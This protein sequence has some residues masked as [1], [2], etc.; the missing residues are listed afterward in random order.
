MAQV[1]PRGAA[2]V[3]AVAGV[4][5]GRFTRHPDGFGFVAP[6][7]KQGTDVFIPPDAIGSR[8]SYGPRRDPRASVIRRRQSSPVARLRGAQIRLG[9]SPVNQATASRAIRSGTSCRPRNSR[10]VTS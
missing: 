5:T 6:L 8:I 1:Q 3:R 10:Y 9:G 4:V 2:P 7:D